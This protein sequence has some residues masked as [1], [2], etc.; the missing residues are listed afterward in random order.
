MNDDT[1]ACKEEYQH[2]TGCRRHCGGRRRET[3]VAAPDPFSNNP[4][5]PGPLRILHLGWAR[6]F[7]ST[8]GP[9]RVGT[10][11]WSADPGRGTEPL[12]GCESIGDSRHDD[13]DDEYQNTMQL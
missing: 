8:P 11:V 4:S 13:D 12:M 9:R 10:E 2:R 3:G 1:S 7:F 5:W 6:G